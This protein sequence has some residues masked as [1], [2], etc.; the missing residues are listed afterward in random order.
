MNY[1]KW[2]KLEYSYKW[3]NLIELDNDLSFISDNLRRWINPDLFNNALVKSKKL[4]DFYYFYKNLFSTNREWEIFMN[5][6]TD[7]ENDLLNLYLIDEDILEN[8]REYLL[9]KWKDLGFNLN[10]LEEYTNFFLDYY[11][12]RNKFYW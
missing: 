11:Y 2:K 12:S 6:D 1:N 4:N 7:I 8:R 9:E 3:Y 5:V 10:D